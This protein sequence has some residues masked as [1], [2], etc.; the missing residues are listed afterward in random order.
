MNCSP[1]GSPVHGILQ[2]G[3]LEWVPFPSPGDLPDPGIEPVSPALAGGFYTTE[4]PEKPILWQPQTK[5]WLPS[6]PQNAVNIG[7]AQTS[8]G[9]T[10]GSWVATRHCPSHPQ[11]RQWWSR[12]S[13]PSGT[14]CWFPAERST[15]RGQ[16]TCLLR[17]LGNHL[18][19]HHLL[20]ALS[21]P[22]CCSLSWGTLSGIFCPALMLVLGAL[23]GAKR[24]IPP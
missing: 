19:S 9:L 8:P 23:P 14:G 10:P 2:A 18:V 21:P 6:L 22:T 13:I 24:E 7:N 1:P 15:G 4:P 11:V 16:S 17:A 12:P 5:S 3:I 20:P